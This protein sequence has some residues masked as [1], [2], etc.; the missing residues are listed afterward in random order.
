MIAPQ[1]VPETKPVLLVVDDDPLITDTLA[2]ALGLTPPDCWIG[3]PIKEAFQ[4]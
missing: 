3:K 4:P 1:S 2:Y